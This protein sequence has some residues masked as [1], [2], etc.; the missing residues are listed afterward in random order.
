MINFFDEIIHLTFSQQWQPY[1]VVNIP[2]QDTRFLVTH[3]NSVGTGE[4]SRYK[5][6]N[7]G[8]YITLAFNRIF[9]NRWRQSSN[10]TNIAYP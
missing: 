6:V 1:N 3:Y 7:L 10:R 8:G 5:L 2:Q 4:P 9:S